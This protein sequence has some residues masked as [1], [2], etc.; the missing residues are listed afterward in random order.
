MTETSSALS[1]E[2]FEL[3]VDAQRFILSALPLRHPASAEALQ[4]FLIA[5]RRHRVAAAIR[6]V[7][8]LEV[9]TILDRRTYGRVPSLVERYLAESDDADPCER[10]QRCVEDVLKYRGIANPLVRRAIAMIEQE[11]ANPQFRL[12]V[13]AQMLRRR[14]PKV[15]ALF[16]AET[17]RTVH[18]YLKQ[19]RL[20]RAAER[21]STTDQRVKQIWASL[22]YN[23]ASDFDH[24][25]RA[26]FGMTPSAYRRSAI[27]SPV[28]EP[29]SI[30]KVC[31]PIESAL[32][33]R[34]LPMDRP[35]RTVLIVDDDDGTRE[36]IAT[37][38]RLEGYEVTT[39][40]TAEECLQH[41]TGGAP[42]TIL[43]DYRLGDSDGLECLR[44]LRR[45]Y[46]TPSIPVILFSADWELENHNDEIR[47]LNATVASKL[48][49]LDD[50]HKLIARTT[51][52][53]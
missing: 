41:V 23:H 18:E 30:A 42:G 14:S 34:R 48:C 33:H 32:E 12:S 9:L 39:V 20:V 4:R 6:R 38:L 17:G 35:V 29:P 3:I 16:K 5:A 10:F 36:T 1:D 51:S 46:P 44:M 25:F 52:R 43:L 31:G 47:Q 45:L 28:G 37:Y 7:V 21:L 50:L 53:M 2:C 13:L 24:Q 11:F 40:A 27:R 19:L 22:G 49:D 15:A 26:Q 8:L